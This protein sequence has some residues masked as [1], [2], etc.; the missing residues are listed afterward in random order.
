[1]IRTGAWVVL[2]RVAT[3]LTLHPDRRRPATRSEALRLL[4]ALRHL[5][6]AHQWPGELVE[7]LIGVLLFAQGELQQL[8]DRRSCC[9]RF[10]AVIEPDISSGPRVGYADGGRGLQPKET[11][12][13]SASLIHS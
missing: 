9:A 2:W 13:R 4:D 5:G 1:M 12:S 11:I 10:R 8:H 6:H 7:E 3:T